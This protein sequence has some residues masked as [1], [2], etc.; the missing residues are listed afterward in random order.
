MRVDIPVGLQLL[1][2]KSVCAVDEEDC[3]DGFVTEVF[4]D[5]QVD[6]GIALLHRCPQNCILNPVE[7]LLEVCGDIVEVL[8]VLQ[9]F[10]T[11]YS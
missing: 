11:K 7:G 6:A 5:S 4:D 9:M 2:G 10:L 1:F 3:T 8:L